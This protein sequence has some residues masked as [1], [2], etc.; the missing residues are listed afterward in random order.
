MHNKL[1]VLEYYGKKL[2][3]EKS[4]GIDL[5]LLYKIQEAQLNLNFRKTP[6]NFS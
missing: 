6:N 1:G 5:D 3:G 4:T 2:E